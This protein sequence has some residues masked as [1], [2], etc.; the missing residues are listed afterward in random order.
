MTDQIHDHL[1]ISQYQNKQIATC[2]IT[3]TLLAL[4]QKFLA[5][6][7]YSQVGYPLLLTTYIPSMTSPPYSCQWLHCNI[8]V[9]R[10]LTLST[11][12]CCHL[13]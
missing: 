6:Q 5:G 8:C 3:T 13:M 4:Q 7:C 11:E 10:L 9:A 2:Y 1:L 12:I